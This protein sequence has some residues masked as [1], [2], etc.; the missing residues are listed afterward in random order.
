LTV[1]GIGVMERKIE[2]GEGVFS[3]IRKDAHVDFGEVLESIGTAEPHPCR[4]IA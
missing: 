3:D 2:H 4:V 1:E